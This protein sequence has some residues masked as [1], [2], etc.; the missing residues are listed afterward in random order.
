MQR[1]KEYIID[2]FH[3]FIFGFIYHDIDQCIRAQANYVVALA[4]LS[5]TEY[6]GALVSGH[7]GLGNKGRQS[8]RKALSYFPEEYKQVNDSI[9]IQ[10]V[11]KDGKPVLEKKGKKKGKP[12]QEKEIYGLFRCGLVHEYFIKGES[13]IYNDPYGPTKSHIGIIKTGGKLEF[14]TNEYFRDFRLAIDKIYKL[15]VLD[16]NPKLMEG[17]NKSLDRISSRK[18][19]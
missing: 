11:D 17:F 1:S 13:I 9:V 19:L 12:K 16:S 4:L 2:Y 8:F 6:L 7:I 5:Y 3:E 15:L 14:H 10:Y 18:I